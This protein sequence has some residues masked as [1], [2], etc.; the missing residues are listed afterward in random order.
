MNSF[1]I[2]QVVVCVDASKHPTAGDVGEYPVEGDVYTIRSF[3]VGPDELGLRLEEIINPIYDFEG[4]GIGEVAF[5]S[6]RF[7]PAK[8]TSLDVFE[9]ALKERPLHLEEV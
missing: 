1:H 7:R 8:K 5:L 3:S 9:V 4:E 2:G 6:Y